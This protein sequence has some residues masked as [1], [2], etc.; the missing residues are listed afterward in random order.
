MDSEQ[1]QVLEIEHNISKAERYLWYTF[2][3]FWF[4]LIT[5][6]QLVVGKI[7]NV[8]CTH[9]ICHA[10]LWNQLKMQMPLHQISPN[11]FQ[12]IQDWEPTLWDVA[13][14]SANIC[15][16]THATVAIVDWNIP[17]TYID[18][19]YKYANT[20]L[21]NFHVDSRLLLYCSPAIPKH[22]SGVRAVGLQALCYSYTQHL[23]VEKS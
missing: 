4:I 21:L 3:V 17:L 10:M 2:Q 16:H 11:Y 12:P 7:W 13:L 22:L 18:P 20:I 8:K 15:T 6:L 5:Q 9:A 14:S 1:C 23:K 19:A